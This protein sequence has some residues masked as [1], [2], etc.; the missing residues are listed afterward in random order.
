M[1]FLL[2]LL[3]QFVSPQ[4]AFAATGCEAALVDVLVQA[5]ADVEHAYGNGINQKCLNLA[6]FGMS[7]GRQYCGADGTQEVM[8]RLQPYLNRGKQICRSQCAREGKERE[9][10]SLL[11]NAYLAGS[12]TDGVMNV[13]A[14]GL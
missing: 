14:Q 3:M 4:K 5:V 12:G 7:R 2:V 9:C 10:L 6:H 13:L 1:T 11:S 8:N